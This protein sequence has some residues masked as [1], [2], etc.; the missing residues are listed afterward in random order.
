MLSLAYTEELGH[1][2]VEEAFARAVGLYPLAV[3]N[4][5]RNGALADVGKNEVSGAGDLLDIDLV[6]GNVVGGEEALG[7]AAVAAPG[8][9]VDSQLNCSILRERRYCSW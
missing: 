5:L 9:S 7:F 1:L 2:V 6:V 3:E 4:E 8:S